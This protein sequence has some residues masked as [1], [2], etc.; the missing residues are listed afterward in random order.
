MTGV[1]PRASDAD[2]PVIPRDSD[3]TG[4]EESAVSAPVGRQIPR[5]PA[6][7]S[8]YE[9]T[10]RGLAA[11]AQLPRFMPAGSAEPVSD[12]EETGRGLAALAQLPRFMPAGSAEPVSDC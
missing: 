4:P 1:I 8:S 12:Y 9:E 5:R 2:G 10:G 6:R 7:R 11:L 3:W